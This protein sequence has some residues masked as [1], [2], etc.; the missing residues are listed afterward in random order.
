MEK[1]ITSPTVLTKINKACILNGNIV[2]FPNAEYKY[3]NYELSIHTLRT[4]FGECVRIEFESYMNRPCIVIS[5]ANFFITNS[6]SMG[7]DVELE[8]KV[9]DPL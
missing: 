5:N 7:A 1:I 8:L 6:E 9:N 4:L 3:K 2:V